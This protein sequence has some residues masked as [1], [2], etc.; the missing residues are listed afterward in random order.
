MFIVAF[1][2]PIAVLG[3]SWNYSKIM[4]MELANDSQEVKYGLSLVSNVL[5]EN[6]N[7]I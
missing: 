2:D 3:L 4:H 5:D 7:K 6:I 1:M